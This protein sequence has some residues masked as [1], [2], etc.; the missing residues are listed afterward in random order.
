MGFELE[1][2]KYDE[3]NA[4]DGDG[5]GKDCGWISKGDRRELIERY[6]VMGCSF[7]SRWEMGRC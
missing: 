1:V 2:E 6:W 3:L 4:C 5:G 7:P